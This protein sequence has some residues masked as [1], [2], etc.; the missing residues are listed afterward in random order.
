MVF[1]SKLSVLKIIMPQIYVA[2]QGTVA[3]IYLPIILR[4]EKCLLQ[5]QFHTWSIS[6]LSGVPKLVSVEVRQR[7]LSFLILILVFCAVDFVVVN[8]RI[9]FYDIIIDI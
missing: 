3:D 1:I 7:L 5:S 6:G 8:V 9:C 2:T 4:R